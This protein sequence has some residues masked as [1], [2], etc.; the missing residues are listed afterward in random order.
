MQLRSSRSGRPHLRRQHTVLLVAA[1]VG[2]A[3]GLVPAQ[4]AGAQPSRP[5]ASAGWKA[6]PLSGTKVTA[7]TAPSARLARTDP[8]LLG[9]TSTD[10][11]SVVVKFD[12]DSLSAYRGGVAGFAP[13]SP[14]ATGRRLT[15]ANPDVSRYE[16]YVIATE[17]RILSTVRA[18]VPGVRVGRK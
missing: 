2:L 17:D 6:I 11:V 14:E 10:P 18:K 12:Y 3:A 4:Q 8:S 15:R 7:A 16:K 1:A 5:A 13:T 9:Q